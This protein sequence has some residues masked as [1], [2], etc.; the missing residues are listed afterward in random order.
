M[1][2]YGEPALKLEPV[3]LSIV[4]K[5]GEAEAE[6]GEGGAARGG[7]LVMVTPQEGCQPDS[8][9]GQGCAVACA[10]AGIKEGGKASKEERGGKQSG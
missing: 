8:L 7:D 6:G 3:G 1:L 2:G 9:H 4:Q 10:A 5:E